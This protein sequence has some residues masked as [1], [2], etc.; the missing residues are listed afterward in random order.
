MAFTSAE[1]T[2]IKRHLGYNAVARSWFPLVESNF[3]VDDILSNVPIDTENDVRTILG[4]LTNLE[5]QLDAAPKYLVA[6][7]VEDITLRGPVQLDA[8]WGEIRRWRREMSIE[9]GLPNRRASAAMM[10]T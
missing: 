7:Q 9:L 5:A 2:A 6:S 8:L 3:A 1:I 4:R 10:V